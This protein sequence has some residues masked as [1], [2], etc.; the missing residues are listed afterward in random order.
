MFFTLRFFHLRRNSFSSAVSSV[1]LRTMAVAATMQ[2]GSLC[3]MDKSASSNSFSRSEG[4]TLPFVVRKITALVSN[5]KRL[6]VIPLVPEISLVSYSIAINT[7]RKNTKILRNRST[8]FRCGLRFPDRSRKKD[9]FSPSRRNFGRNVNSQP[10]ACR[11]LYSLCNAHK[12]N[13]A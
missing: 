5:T 4:I 3:F 13:I 7:R 11:Y 12:V 9:Y 6:L 2:S 10:V 1:A 8:T